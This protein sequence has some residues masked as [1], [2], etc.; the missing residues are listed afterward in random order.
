MLSLSPSISLVLQDCGKLWANMFATSNPK[1]TL[2]HRGGAPKSVEMGERGGGTAGK[3]E[4]DM[5]LIRVLQW[6]NT[7]A[8]T[9]DWPEKPS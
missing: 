9:K 4:H 8:C 2:A 1:I 6:V 5:S 7:R 3:R